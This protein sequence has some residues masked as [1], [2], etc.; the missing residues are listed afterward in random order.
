M[1]IRVQTWL[2]CDGEVSREVSSDG[3]CNAI[4]GEREHEGV[5]P[6]EHEG[7]GPRT[8][9]ELRQTA[10]ID[11]WIRRRRM[12]PDGTMYYVDLCPRCASR[13]PELTI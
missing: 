13:E 3:R 2:I 1:S 12:V 6:R 9:V 4:G 7:G 10:Q 11:G 5:I 8:I